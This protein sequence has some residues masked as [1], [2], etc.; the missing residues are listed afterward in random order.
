[1]ECSVSKS[2][3]DRLDRL[4]RGNRRW[5]LCSLT[6]IAAFALLGLVGAKTAQAPKRIIAEEIAVVDKDGFPRITMSVTDAGPILTFCPT[7]GRPRLYMGLGGGPDENDA[8]FLN[9]R[10]KSGLPILTMGLSS[11]RN[12]EPETPYFTLNSQRGL[13]RLQ[14]GL[15]LGDS[16]YLY[17][18]DKR[19]DTRIFLGMGAEDQLHFRTMDG[20]GKEFQDHFEMRSSNANTPQP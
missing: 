1:M 8:P 6:A 16:P 5:R 9:F 17:F 10:A 12:D 2:V 18:N 11:H 3:N 4:E 19:S 7:N 15:G 14:C 20:K 13:A